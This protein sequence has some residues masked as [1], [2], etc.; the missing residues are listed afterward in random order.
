MSFGRAIPSGFSN[1]TNFSGRATWSEFWFWLLFTV[2]G[3]TTAAILDTIFFT[4]HR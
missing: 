2:I 1:Y 4:Y 3:G